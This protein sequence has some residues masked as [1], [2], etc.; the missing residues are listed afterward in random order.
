MS[1]SDYTEVNMTSVVFPVGS[2]NNDTLCVNITIMDDNLIE[3]DEVFTVTVMSAFD[4][5]QTIGIGVTDVT[6]LDDE[7]N[8]LA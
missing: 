6:I 5:S 4:T 8:N 7:S 2:E 3:G 1:G